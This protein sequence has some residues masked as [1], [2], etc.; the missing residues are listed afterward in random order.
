[1]AG[2]D[3]NARGRTPFPRAT[4]AF[5][6]AIA[7]D[8]LQMCD[9]LGETA[10]E[11]ARVAQIGARLVALTHAWALARHVGSVVAWVEEAKRAFGAAGLV[12]MSSFP[13]LAERGRF[14]AF[15]ARRG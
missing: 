9:P 6:G 10:V 12:D 2:S 8:T 13:A 1:M 4:G 11:L 15:V 7:V 5:D 3:S 14:I